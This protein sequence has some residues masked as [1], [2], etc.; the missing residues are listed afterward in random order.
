M[1]AIPRWSIAAAL[2]LLALLGIMLSQPGRE[3]TPTR[4]N[5]RALL[6]MTPLSTIS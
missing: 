4:E 2:A 6:V 3:W 5:V 1:K